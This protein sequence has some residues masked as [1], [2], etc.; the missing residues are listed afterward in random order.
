MTLP[1][2]M[3]ANRPEPH[4]GKVRLMLVD[5]SMVIRTLVARWIELEPDFE[6]TGVAADGA[7]AVQMLPGL[8]ADVCI[9]DLEMPVMG[10]LE[11]LPRLLRLR[12]ELKVLIAS[13]LTRAGAEATLR[14]MEAGAADCLPKPKA[15]DPHGSEIFR[16]DL[17]AKARALARSENKATSPRASRPAARSRLRPQGS[18]LE[19]IEVMVVAASTGGPLALRSFLQGLDRDLRAPVLVVQHMP[20][21]FIELLADQLTKISPL[22][23]SVAADGQFLDPRRVYLAPG[24]RHLRLI[25]EGVRLRA[26]LGDEPAENYCRPAADALFRSAAEICGS[27]VLAVVLTGMGQ[28]GCKGASAI[29]KAGGTVLAQDEESSVVWGM[30]GAVAAAG[31]ATEIAPVERLAEMARALAAGRKP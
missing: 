12:P 26:R 11:A 27:K 14:A 25:R 22:P 21:A 17:L 20:E 18:R 19:P 31:L 15:A 4:A 13:R 8:Q 16:R 28:D 6:L 5:D 2:A 7:E 9:L 3:R 1:A 24:G 23:V 10:G 29:V 30:P